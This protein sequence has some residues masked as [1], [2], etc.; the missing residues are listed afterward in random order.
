M[1]L[2]RPQRPR[3]LH[4][5]TLKKGVRDEEVGGSNPLTP[6]IYCFPLSIGLGY[7]ALDLSK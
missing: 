4:G 7:L 2:S 6:T 3:E 1:I 5:D